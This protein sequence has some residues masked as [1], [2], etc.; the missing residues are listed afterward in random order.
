[1]ATQNCLALTIPGAYVY[2]EAGGSEEARCGLSNTSSVAA[3]ESS[4]RQN[5]I[6]VEGESSNY[7]FYINSNSLFM[8]NTC[9]V[10][11]DLQVYFLNNVEVPS[12][13]NKSIWA[14]VELC[15]KSFIGSGPAYN[16]QARINEKLKDITDQCISK[17]EKKPFI[18]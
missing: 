8:G 5:R 15:S 3:V 14:T 16:M 6:N 10:N 13:K 1:M 11:T 17:I 2:S 18:K 7:S 4:L 9:V 12:Q